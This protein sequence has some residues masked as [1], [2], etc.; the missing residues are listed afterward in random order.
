MKM[1]IEV[2]MDA[3]ESR[4]ATILADVCDY[5]INITEIT[6]V[7][8]VIEDGEHEEHSITD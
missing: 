2:E 8:A 7:E 1:W 6:E 5:L 3:E 4:G